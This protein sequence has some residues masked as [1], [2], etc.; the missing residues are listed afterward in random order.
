[1]SLKYPEIP[2][3]EWYN[4]IWTLIDE[5]NEETIPIFKGGRTGYAVRDKNLKSKIF[6][7]EYLD[8][9]FTGKNGAPPKKYL[10]FR[11]GKGKLVMKELLECKERE[12]KEEAEFI[13]KQD[14]YYVERKKKKSDLII[15]YGF[16][17]IYSLRNDVMERINK[18][19]L[20]KMK[21]IYSNNP[22]TSTNN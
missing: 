4:I 13:K 22:F 18:I 7:P 17:D 20:E 5:L 21:K 6:N 11:V 10:N 19:G 16:A 9:E 1:M 3:K 12:M 8:W 14:L 2:E 15:G